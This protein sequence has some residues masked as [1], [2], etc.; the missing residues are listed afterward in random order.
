[1]G[2]RDIAAQQG[3]EGDSPQLTY[4]GFW[5]RFIA[6]WVD[7]LVIAPPLIAC[8]MAL[9]SSRVLS[10]VL[11]LP[12]QALSLSYAIVLHARSGQTLGKRLMRICVVR[13]TGDKIAW[14]EA[15]RRSSVDI[16]LGFIGSVSS[17]I[18]MSR[19]PDAG[20]GGSWLA[21]A[22][23]LKPL[24]PVW[25]HW[26]GIALQVWIWS[27]VVVMLLNRKRRALHDFIAGTV[28]VNAG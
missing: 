23:Q 16:G 20:W 11:A 8:H 28:V 13:T 15:V 21:L 6:N 7:V 1:M 9:T 27:E 2:D 18:A 14:R 12:L 19:L 24:E 17:M 10:L 26:A 25:G 5:A 4:A 22:K 3:P